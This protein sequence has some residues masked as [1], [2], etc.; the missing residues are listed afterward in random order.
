MDEALASVI[1]KTSVIKNE[2]V[3]SVIIGSSKSSVA[4]R[5]EDLTTDDTYSSIWP[6]EPNG[7]TKLPASVILIILIVVVILMAIL[8]LLVSIVMSW[9]PG[10]RIRQQDL[11]NSTEAPSSLASLAKKSFFR[12]GGNYKHVMDSSAHNPMVTD[13]DGTITFESS[14]RGP[15][16]ELQERNIPSQIYGT[17]EETEGGQVTVEFNQPFSGLPMSFVAVKQDD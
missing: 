2:G 11:R 12:V 13:D 3:N 1:T 8:Y 7:K 17:E 15:E 6:E 9:G 14:T 5:S 16:V 10:K 4:V